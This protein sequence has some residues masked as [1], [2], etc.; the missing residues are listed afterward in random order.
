[1]LDIYITDAPEII[2]E[3]NNQ[4]V[5]PG[6]IV[7]ASVNRAGVSSSQAAPAPRQRHV[8]IDSLD[9]LMDETDAVNDGATTPSSTT[10]VVWRPMSSY[11]PP[12]DPVWPGNSTVTSTINVS[13]P[14]SSAAP[15]NGPD[16]T[17]T[18]TVSSTASNISDAGPSGYPVL[19]QQR[20]ERMAA[21]GATDLD[22]TRAV[23][24]RRLTPSSSDEMLPRPV[25]GAPNSATVQRIP[26]PV[27]TAHTTASNN[28]PPLPPSPMQTT[29]S[30]SAPPLPTAPPPTPATPS[31]Q[32]TVRRRILEPDSDRSMDYGYRP[33]DTST[34][35]D[36]V[37]LLS[38]SQG[39]ISPP[40]ETSTPESGRRS[41]AIVDE[42]LQLA[43]QMA[44]GF[45]GAPPPVRSPQLAPQT[46]LERST[47]ELAARISRETSAMLASSENLS[48][49]ASFVQSE[50]TSN[51]RH[52]SSDESVTE[53]MRRV[54]ERGTGTGQDSIEDLDVSDQE[55]A[56]QGY[57]RAP[58]REA[59]V[60]LVQERPRP[61]PYS[62]NPDGRQRAVM[63]IRTRGAPGAGGPSARG[64]PRQAHRRQVPLLI[65]PPHGFC[66][67]CN[68]A[69]YTV[70]FTPQNQSLIVEFDFEDS[71]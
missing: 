17:T 60:P 55:I 47:K 49:D 50:S 7:Y 48:T 61:P 32:Y 41:S 13:A 34:R 33:L 52:Q 14:P 67:T 4:G 38:E 46:Q 54:M 59:P 24:K 6:E 63:R 45:P 16:S 21:C 27:F 12:T 44:V 30:P 65:N 25:C 9:E 23:S 62:R 42:T 18:T 29:Q 31:T 43:E 69:E 15:V 5:D 57:R 2:F 64:G 71:E 19:L 26:A 58:A 40:N 37:P 35:S 66:P 70:L 28:Y 53:V 1:M 56:R 36:C 8:S 51:P 11:A 3:S 10:P 22:N 20:R 68:S 39:S